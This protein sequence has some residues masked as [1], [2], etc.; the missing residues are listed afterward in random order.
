MLYSLAQQEASSPAVTTS[1]PPTNVFESVI[2]IFSRPDTLAHPE[3]LIQ[4]LQSMSAVWAVIFLTTGLICL[5]LG[6]KI[7]KTVTIVLALSIGAFLGYYLGKKINAE[8]V[9]AGCFAVL[10]AVGAFPLMNYAVSALGGLAGAFLGANAWTAIERLYYNGA[11][12][13][14]TGHYWVG[15]MAGLIIGA[16]LAFILFKMAVVIFTSVSGSTIA[17]LGAVALLMQVPLFEPAV[18][19]SIMAH[20]TV[21]PL[22]VF[23]PATIGFI[24]QETQKDSGGKGGAKA[25]AKAAA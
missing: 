6:Y 16:M 11:D 23:V 19:R 20:A 1:A 25:G 8:Y 17:V 22:L 12:Y 21:L 9:V 14:P 2:T 5:I 7:Y 13:T 15:A 4:A 24:L 10:L 3:G 18:T